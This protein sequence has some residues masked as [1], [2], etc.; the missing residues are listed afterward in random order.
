LRNSEVPQRDEN[1]HLRPINSSSNKN[2][3]SL[4][5]PKPPKRKLPSTPEEQ[6]ARGFALRDRLRDETDRGKIIVA[7]SY[8]DEELELVIRTMMRDLPKDLE[9]E[10]FRGY[11]PLASFSGKIKL[12]FALKIINEAIYKD[13][14]V[15]KALR[16]HFAHA[17]SHDS[18]Y[19][20][21]IQESAM[22]LE[23]GNTDDQKLKD[24]CFSLT[25]REEKQPNDE[26][27][28]VSPTSVSTILV[29]TFQIATNLSRIRHNRKQSE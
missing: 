16:N 15:I 24:F 12:A 18:A 13:L 27:W 17:Y 3:I 26:Y 11:G 20:N 9:A 5:V 7:A 28:M 19:D 4:I 2:Y 6:S 21:W 23:F 1:P 22:S 8:L 25:V 14:L 29:A 10:L